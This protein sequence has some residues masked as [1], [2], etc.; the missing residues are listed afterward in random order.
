MSEKGM[1]E[2]QYHF[3]PSKELMKIINIGHAIDELLK[4]HRDAF[5][6][7]HAFWGRRILLPI[8]VFC[9]KESNLNLI[10]HLPIYREEN[11][12]YCWMTP[13]GWYW[14]NYFSSN[15]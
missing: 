11:N 3:A 8:E 14:H 10:E 12:I 4:I 5:F 6:A 15:F 1:M 13:K 7:S 9:Q 2:L